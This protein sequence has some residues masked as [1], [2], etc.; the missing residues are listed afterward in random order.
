MN[1]PVSGIIL[2]PCTLAIWAFRPS[3]LSE[4]AL[5]VTI[6]QA[7]AVANIG[8]SFSF[9][10][11]PYFLVAI[12]IGAR[13]LPQW[14]SGRVRFLRGEPMMQHIRLLALFAAWAVISALALPVLFAGTPVDDPRKGVDASFFN[15]MPLHWSFSNAGQA[16]Y[17]MLNFII[18][19]HMLQMSER[20]GYL[21]RL[22]NV[23]TWSGVCVVAIGAYQV[24]GSRV[25]LKFPAWLFNSNAEWG[26]AYHQAFNGI[27]R[28]S[29][30]FV[31]PSEAAG[32]LSAWALFELTVAIT[33][34]KNSGWHWMCVI[35]GTLAL[36]ETAS[37]T[38]YVT[39]AVMWAAICFTVIKGVIIRGRLNA[40][41]LLAVTIM[42]LGVVAAL[43][44]MPSTHQIL[45]AVLFQKSTSAS[46][47]HRTATFGRAITVFD[48]T[49][50]LGAGLGS[51]RAM[52]LFFYV[53]SNL[54]IPGV[55][56]L[57]GLWFQLWSGYWRCV[58]Q[59]RAS[60]DGQFVQ[61]AAA[62]FAANLFTLLIA[63]A[64]VTAPR[65][66]VS[67]GMLVAGLRHA[68]LTG[69]AEHET[70]PQNWALAW[71]PQRQS[72]LSRLVTEG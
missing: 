12:L 27:L 43:A 60:A 57:C 10:V 2:I 59:S 41:A 6:F 68:W 66:W 32:F 56:M 28:L 33:R 39:V 50:S 64:E 16:L 15:Q 52:S 47:I 46:A 25:G 9:G 29:A 65:L 40:R 11:G 70:A 19:L 71:P 53:L 18:V 69:R 54:G 55:L 58:R 4:W 61:A 14:Y 31:E 35:A 51:N 1:V 36:M 7:A 63:G 42:G 48:A 37:T 22:Q 34:A 20:P 62:A 21:K 24:M 67:W 45:G 8:A 44:A 23:F 38:G 17:M 3:R 5:F 30:S 49:L 13:L 72:R 26:Q